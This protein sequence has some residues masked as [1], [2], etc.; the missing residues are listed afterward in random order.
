MT[1]QSADVVVIQKQTAFERY[2]EGRFEK[3]HASHVQTRSALLALLEKRKLK[4]C[5]YHLDDLRNLKIPFYHE[6]KPH[7]GLQPKKKLVISLGGDGTLLHAS[8]HVGGD[9]R[10]LGINS[11]PQHSVGHM[12]FTKPSDLEQKLD[13]ALE[14]VD[15]T[16]VFSR[17][18]VQLLLDPQA[19][20]LALN[21]V[22]FCNRHPAATSRYRISVQNQLQQAKGY[23]QSENHV[24]SGV[25]IAT[26]AGRTAAIASY[27]FEEVPMTSS[28]VF[29]A[30]REPYSPPG[31]SLEMVKFS[32]E[33]TEKSLS[34]FSQMRQGLVC[35][36]GPDFCA[37]VSFDEVVDISSPKGSSLLLI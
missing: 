11:S 17:L 28:R 8:H 20:P 25:W 29:V 32:F 10:L 4:T 13:Q 16:S 22:L 6:D 7:S 36:D 12:C 21:D 19:L 27:G 24:S 18:R 30:T 15:Q 5:V 14:Q 3:A 34:F 26:S 31:K 23:E 35:V 2:K 33:G 9:V 1:T 37:S